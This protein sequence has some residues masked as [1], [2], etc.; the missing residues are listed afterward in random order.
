MRI[1]HAMADIWKEMKASTFRQLRGP[2]HAKRHLK[3]RSLT[4]WGAVLAAMNSPHLGRFAAVLTDTTAGLPEDVTLVALRALANRFAAV[5]GGMLEHGLWQPPAR[6]FAIFEHSVRLTHHIQRAFADTY[7][8]VAPHKVPIEGCFMPKFLADPFLEMAD[9]IA[10]VV[11]RNIKYRRAHPNP[12]DYTPQF[13]A[14][15]RDVDRSL[16]SYME[17]TAVQ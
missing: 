13:Q 1:P 10:N 12:A 3:E 16:A 6:V 8:E 9:C 15:F 17:V 5:A 4:Q 2:L 7:M 11:T 14:L